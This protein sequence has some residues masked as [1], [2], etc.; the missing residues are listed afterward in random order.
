MTRNALLCIQD[1]LLCLQDDVADSFGAFA[2][3]IS[4]HGSLLVAHID[5]VVAL[6]TP[7]FRCS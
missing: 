7:C 5:A 2:L 4:L 3:S 6:Q 1:V